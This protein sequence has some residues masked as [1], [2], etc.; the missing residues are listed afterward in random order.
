MEKK[1]KYCQSILSEGK[2]TKK[3]RE[4]EREG[5]IPMVLSL[6]VAIPFRGGH[7][8]YLV[9][10]MFTLQFTTAANSQL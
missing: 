6:W 3:K 1:K 8:A 5:T 10:K 9:Y 7:I 4:R 2:Q